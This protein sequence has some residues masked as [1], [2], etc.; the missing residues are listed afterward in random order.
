MVGRWK[1]NRGFQLKTTVALW[2]L[3]VSYTAVR[4]FRW[5]PKDVPMWV[6]T[7]G[8]TS[9]LPVLQLSGWATESS[10]IHTRRVSKPA[11]HLV[12]V[13]AYLVAHRFAHRG[14]IHN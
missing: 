13:V 12:H 5:A 10:P 7:A 11:A 9:C 8:T 4:A 1:V 14:C 2:I 3:E 6:A